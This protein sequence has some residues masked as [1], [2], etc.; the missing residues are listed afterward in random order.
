MRTK[1]AI[2]AG[3]GSICVVN[4]RLLWYNYKRKSKGRGGASI[5]HKKQE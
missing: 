5:R 4:I 3:C 2:Y 1:A